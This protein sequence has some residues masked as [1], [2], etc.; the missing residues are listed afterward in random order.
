MIS[1]ILLCAAALLF[2]IAGFDGTLFHHGPSSL[3]A[4]GLFAW[5]LATLLGGV[6]PAVPWRKT[7]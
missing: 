5:V 7:E 1:L 6:G 4:F 2:L 3:V